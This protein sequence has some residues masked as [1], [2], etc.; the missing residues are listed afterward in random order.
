MSE[1]EDRK[2]ESLQSLIEDEWEILRDLKS[3][4]KNPELS[5]EEKLKVANALAYHASV[6]SKL[7]SQKGAGDQLNEETLGDFIKDVEP[8]IARRVKVGFR[9][10]MRRPSLKR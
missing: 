6:L 10:W 9:H 7:I 2:I 3:T 4:M 8:R 5:V 1:R